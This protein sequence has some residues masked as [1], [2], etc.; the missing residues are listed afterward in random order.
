MNGVVSHSMR[1]KGLDYKLI[2]GVE[3]PRLKEIAAQFESSQLLAEALWIE[4]SRE[5]KILATMLYPKEQ[6]TIEVANLWVED[7]TNIEMARLLS[8]NLLQHMSYAPVAS[9]SWIASNRE[10]VQVVGY[11]TISRLLR[12]TDDMDERAADEFTNQAIAASVSGDYH[13]RSAAIQ[14]LKSFMQMNNTHK[15]ML[16]NL[17][18]NYSNSEVEN[19]KLLYNH[20]QEEALYL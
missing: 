8:M 10:F 20:V 17:T 13:L 6:F 19:E 1:K 12:T 9:F 11:L 14:A 5:C 2:F 15:E 3:L 7:I 16:L 18:S 4:N